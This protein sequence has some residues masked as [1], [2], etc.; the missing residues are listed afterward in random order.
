MIDC[1]KNR[2]KQQQGQ[3]LIPAWHSNDDNL[4]SYG[5]SQVE[6]IH[7][8]QGEMLSH[9]FVYLLSFFVLFTVLCIGSIP[10]LGAAILISIVNDKRNRNKFLAN[11]E[12]RKG[13]QLV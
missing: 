1:F 9:F 7:V 13:L 8:H 10:L 4:C 5:N 11:V 6:Y 12:T 2:L 3:T